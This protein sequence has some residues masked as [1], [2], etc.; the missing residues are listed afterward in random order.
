MAD[1]ADK[2]EENADICKKSMAAALADSKTKLQGV[3]DG[4]K[5]TALEPVL[6]YNAAM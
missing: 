3:V 5:T 1:T 2:F 4:V 6:S